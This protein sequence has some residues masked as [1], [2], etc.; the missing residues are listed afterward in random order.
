MPNLREVD[1]SGVPTLSGLFS[2]LMA[3]PICFKCDNPER[4]CTCE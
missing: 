2:I 3:G 4:E 1:L